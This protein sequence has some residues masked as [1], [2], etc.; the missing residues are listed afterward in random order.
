MLKFIMSAFGPIKGKHRHSYV[1]VQT[2]HGDMINHLNARSLWKC[3]GCGKTIT[4]KE[5]T[6]VV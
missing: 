6:R 2:I 5:L 4:S 1:R 3:K